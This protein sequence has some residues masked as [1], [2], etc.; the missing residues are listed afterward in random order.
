VKLDTRLKRTIINISLRFARFRFREGIT[1]A[2]GTQFL[3][4][5]NIGKGTR[6][7]GPLIVKGGGVLTVGKYCA[8]GGDIHVITDNHNLSHANIQ[9]VLQRTIS[10]CVYGAA[11][12][13]VAIGNNVWIGDCAIILPGVVIGD[14]SVI[15][16]GAV[17]T[18]HVSPF[19]V[20]AG[21]PA[22]I[23]GKRFS[24]EIA[25]FFLQI[26][27]WDWSAKKIIK[28]RWLFEFDF[29]SFAE[30]AFDAEDFREKIT[31]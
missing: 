23:I 30:N 28:N 8:F 13:D 3:S 11:K 20:C 7:N 29:T 27:W 24:E 25:R 12:K 6:V 31:E 10:G 19:S 26:K 1:I 5:T 4:R 22:R 2:R 21:N 17:V 16:A 15:G 14:G 18:R 9:N